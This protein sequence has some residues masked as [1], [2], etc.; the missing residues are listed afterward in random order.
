[1]VRNDRLGKGLGA[2]I[3]DYDINL[4]GHGKTEEIDLSLID[5][6]PD[7]PRKAFDNKA[8]S[9]LAESIVAHG[10][11]QPII[12]T[13]RDDRYMIVAGE[14][15]YRASRL[16]KID[17]IPV[18][19]T[20]VDDQQIQEIMVIENLQREDLNAIEEANGIDTL[21]RQFNLTQE[22]VAQR[23]GKSRPAIA[24]SLRLLKLP[25]SVK[26]LL[27]IGKITVGHAKCLVAVKNADVIIRLSK[28]IAEKGL[29]VRQL[30]QII[31]EL[32]TSK[33]PKA[34]NVIAQSKVISNIITDISNVLS[35]RVRITG[36]DSQ[37]KIVIDYKSSDEL[38]RIYTTLINK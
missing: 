38:Q 35:A 30:E 3:S 18:I 27:I 10:V 15:R 29:T 22:Q 36:S 25:E 8:L 13:R 26:E 37:G 23:L 5:T 11:I 12:V 1:M 21:I 14:R 24:N 32:Y 28:E 4:E 7:Q 20:E 9:E 16:A 34:T 17:S 2:L 33:S 31:S 19:I 6:N